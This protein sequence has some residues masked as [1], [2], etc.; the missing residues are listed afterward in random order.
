MTTQS[1]N[2]SE[3]IRRWL[4]QSGHSRA[5]LPDSQSL[6]GEELFARFM[7]HLP[8]LAWLKDL[9]GRFVFANDA[10]MK[11]FAPG[12][13]DIAGK[14]NADLLP[15][16]AARQCDAS[17]SD[18][19]K[20]EV[21]VEVLETYVH[22]DGTSR[23]MLV[24]K[25]PIAG[26]DGKV[27]LIGGIAID[28]T[29]RKR[30]EE[31]LR[32]SEERLRVATEAGK[33]G[34][35]EW[36]ITRNAVTWSSAV[37]AMHGLSPGEFDGT[38]ES[39]AALTHPD[40]RAMVMQAVDQALKNQEHY[41]IEF[42]A[43]RPDGN[44]VWV[45][46]HAKV[47]R[48]NGVPVRL[49]GATLDITSRKQTELALRESEERF[50]K[51]FNASPL[52]LTLSSLQTGKLLEVN[53][54]FSQA[55]GYS[56]EEAI[57]RT[58]V[59]LGLWVNTNERDAEMRAVRQAGKVR[60]L[61]YRFRAKDGRE[62]LGLLSAEK[63]EIGGEP[64]TLT[65][66]E[67]I[68][69]REQA[70]QA[71][72]KSERLYRAIGESIDYGV[73]V[74]DPTGKNT[75]ASESFLRLV[76]LTQEQ[77]S[78]FGWG[79]VLHPDDAERTMAAWR[80]C[81]RTGGQWDIQHR[82]RGVDGKW[83]PILARGVPVRNEAGEITA[84]AGINLN[85]SHLKTIEDELREAD[86]RKNEF[87]ATLAHELRNPLAPIR[88]GLEILR[89]TK[90]SG[91]PAEQ[92]RSMMDRQLRQMVRLIDD[93]LDLSRISRGKIDLRLERVELTT[94][95][96]NAL[97]ISQP[98]IA[99]AGHELTIETP[100]ESLFVHADQTRLSQ[101]FANLINNAA[102]YT[103]KGGQ[104]WVTI[105]RHGDKASI[106]IRDNGIGIPAHL[107]PRVFEMFTQDDRSLEKAQGGL[108]I[109]L[110]IAKQLV[111][112]HGGTIEARSDGHGTGSEFVVQLPLLAAHAAQ[113]TS[114][115]AD[116]GR[117]TGPSG[118]RVLVADDN[119]DAATSL[120]LM[121]KIKG[122]E[123]RTA[124]D[125]LEAVHVAEVFSPEVVLL[126]IGMPELNGYEACRQIRQQHD[127]GT[128]LIVAMTG[129]G[130]EE[131]KLRSQQAGFDHH[132]V[133]PVDVSILEKLLEH[134][135]NRLMQRAP[136]SDR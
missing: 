12:L 46:S 131:D 80:E 126:D 6:Q 43:V 55:T 25:F 82:F 129:W 26:P 13:T 20:S 84:W 39:F 54:T 86:Q 87:L 101:V 41:E 115:I 11:A 57:G 38:V 121:L 95:I 42:R 107:L 91:E 79:E 70:Q 32:L 18:A 36:D 17:D 119:V 56:R 59:E 58:T 103:D 105:K 96:R 50:A 120:A 7:R 110:S 69:E 75:Y 76:G 136:A 97:E 2:M 113:I 128:I 3:A 81:V 1:K 118:L 35:W 90:G 47:I 132:L 9:Q 52:S 22:A 21:G 31:N 112:M 83:H 130:Q 88:N 5:D 15:E 14:T 37:Y 111:E 106:G 65:V 85:I 61:E 124:R 109:G 122:N 60:K 125:G 73:W 40:D 134:E 114:I 68:S 100:K 28:I 77:C 8:G 104:I 45:Y 51:A 123:V 29:E 135:V 127:S 64:Y 92:A 48:E 34:V 67:D 63:I 62:I 72:R 89:L 133:K 53:E 94:A 23:I 10:A 30:A 33:V 102:K 93:L 19:A 117:N 27:A 16:D 78:S 98:L 66:I 99:E 4:R 71:L 44:V 116:N 24:N 49:T 108:G 74:C